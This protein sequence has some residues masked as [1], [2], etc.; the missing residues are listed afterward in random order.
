MKA[1]RLQDVLRLADDSY[2]DS[3]EPAMP[4][5]L[6]EP[7]DGGQQHGSDMG[8]HVAMMQVV[9]GQSQ[10]VNNS[11]QAVEKLAEAIASTAKGGSYMFTVI[12]RDKDGLVEQFTATPM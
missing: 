4:D 1:K 11:A 3:G 10:A 12:S 6:P 5:D 9:E 7:T 8:M 2:L